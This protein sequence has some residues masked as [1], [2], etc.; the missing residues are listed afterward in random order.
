MKILLY[1]CTRHR[2][3]SLGHRVSGSSLW[4]SV[5]PGVFQFSLFSR[6]FVL[7]LMLLAYWDAAL[8]VV[9]Q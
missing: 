5:W 7:W 4:P 6:I 8:S 3:G 1:I 2:T 9:N